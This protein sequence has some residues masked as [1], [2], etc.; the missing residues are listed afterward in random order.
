MFYISYAR[1]AG[2]LDVRRMRR[3]KEEIGHLIQEDL[4]I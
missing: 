4:G 2:V 1:N 3:R